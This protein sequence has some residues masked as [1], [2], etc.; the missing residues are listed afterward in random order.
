[1]WA[2]ADTF[3]ALD[4]MTRVRVATLRYGTRAG[5]AID[6]DLILGDGIRV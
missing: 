2:V 3:F 6:P 4:E 1:M 5:I